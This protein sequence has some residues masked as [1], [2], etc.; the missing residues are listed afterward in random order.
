MTV[1]VIPTSGGGVLV[2]TDGAIATVDGVAAVCAETEPASASA[3]AGISARRSIVLMAPPLDNPVGK[4]ANSM[5][6]VQINYAFDPG[7][8]EPVGLLERYITLTGW[9]E[10][11][12]GAGVDVQVVQRFHRDDRV[13]LNGV[14]YLFCSDGSLQSRAWFS[15]RRIARAVAA[16]Q[17]DLVH[18]NGFE[19]GLPTWTLTRRLPTS[20][21]CVVQHHGGGVPSRN[22]SAAR[23]ATRAIHRELLA[24]VDGFFF[25][26]VE[27]ADPWRQIGVIRP[28]HSVHA[29]MEA[30]TTLVPIDRSEARRGVAPADPAILWVGRLDDNK[31][32]LTVLAAFEQVLVELPEARLTM[33]FS[34]DLLAPLVQERV[35][36]SPALSRSVSLLGGLE[37]AIDASPVQRRRPVRARQSS[38]GQWL[39]TPR[40][41]RLRLPSRRDQHSVISRDHERRDSGRQLDARRRRWVPAC[42]RQRCEK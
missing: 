33:A 14:D 37:H 32:P 22:R 9:S 38:R 42:D 31:D 36:N 34:A 30:S 4:A 2:G 10:A 3:I 20:T 27:Q 7:V 6:V 28:D 35:R 39:R 13:R 12:L 1:T 5:R 11:L 17:P 19:F 29:V 41:V 40:G 24:P 15:G 25:S 23:R 18:V 26:T 21:A 16:L 8:R